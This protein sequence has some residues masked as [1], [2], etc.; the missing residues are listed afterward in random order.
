MSVKKR[1]NLNGQ[2][3]IDDLKEARDP[4]GVFSLNDIKL[5]PEPPKFYMGVDTYDKHCHAYC[6]FVY[7]RG[8][9]PE[10]VI[11]KAMTDTA[12]FHEEVKN[13]A[14]YF[15]AKVWEETDPTQLRLP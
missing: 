14:K 1:I 2:Q 5:L 15:N 12:A 4:G 11:A 9:E 13:L 7:K 6:L 8:S 10:I 3:F